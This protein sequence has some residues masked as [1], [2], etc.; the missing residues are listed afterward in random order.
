MSSAAQD[1]FNELIRDKDTSHKHPEDQSALSD[2]SSD[3]QPRETFYEKDDEDSEEE[4]GRDNMV[5]RYYLPSLHSNANT[6]P[7]GVIADAQAYEQ[8]RKASQMRYKDTP[9]ALHPAYSS[10][11]I[12]IQAEEKSSLEE[13][14]GEGFMAKWRANRLKDLQNAV[15][16]TSRSRTRSPTK[17]VYGSLAAVDANGYLEAIEK[18]PADT[19]VVVLIYDDLS[20]I[21]NM[22][23]K[24]VRKLARSH[25]T[26]RFVKLHY[27]DAEFEAAGV[28]AILAYRGGEKFSDMIPIMDE[29]PDDADLSPASLEHAMKSRRILS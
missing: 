26:T 10:E 21:S 6:G 2:D 11:S 15:R 18:V 5:G 22:V 8:A 7:K 24:C 12:I 17:R 27:L 1:E 20:E 29:L 19:V 4:R 13:D 3:D 9:T 28:P 25:A 23:E 14:D 16:H